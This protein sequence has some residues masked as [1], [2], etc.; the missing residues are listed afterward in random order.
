MKNTLS[1]GFF[2]VFEGPD[3]SGK[4]TIANH[5]YELL[6]Q[7]YNE[8]VVFTREP[9]GANNVI[10]EDIRRILLNHL[11]YKIDFRAEALLYAASRAQHVSDFVL[12]HLKDKDIVICDRYIHSSLIYQGFARK[13]GINEVLAINKFAI[14]NV[15]PDLVF[16]I[17]VD[18]E[19]CSQRI[20][21]NRV[22]KLD[23]L[24]LEQDLHK[25]VYEGYQ[26][27][28]ANNKEKNMVVIDSN[29]TIPVI[30]NEVMNH[31]KKLVS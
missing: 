22:N 31:I 16:I 24:D 28:I 29:Q 7:C 14:Q 27:L 18:P 26:T 11:D 8:H 10:A 1:K 20:H 15:M 6:K 5:V 2:I 25:K 19:I 4:S 12:P 30:V 9:G 3:G 23:R 21:E 17:M 13:L